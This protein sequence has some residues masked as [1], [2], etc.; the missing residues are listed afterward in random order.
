MCHRSTGGRLALLLP[1]CDEFSR[2][3][4]YGR[5]T[6]AHSAGEP[7]IVQPQI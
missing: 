1:N 2:K 5:Y 4:T 3:L 7:C 6:A